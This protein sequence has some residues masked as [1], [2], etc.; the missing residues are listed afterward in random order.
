MIHAH[1]H[2][3]RGGP[4]AFS[5]KTCRQETKTRKTSQTFNKQNGT[6]MENCLFSTQN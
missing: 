5:T 1:F 3:S 6:W 4:Q 2:L